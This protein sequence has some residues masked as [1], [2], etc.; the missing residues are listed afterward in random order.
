MFG[1]GSRQRKEVDYSDQ[2]TEKQWLRAIEDGNLDELETPRRKKSRG[3]G[4]GK[5]GSKRKR[6]S[7]PDEGPKDKKKR[8]RPAAEKR[9]PNPTK[10]TAQM[11]KLLAMVCEYK[12]ADDRILIEPFEKLPSRRELPDY[13]EVI[14]KPVDI[15]KMKARIREHRYRSLDDLEEDFMRLCKNAQT[16]NIEDSPIFNDSI[17]LQ[18]VFTSCREKLEREQPDLGED[19]NETDEDEDEEVTDNGHSNVRSSS[20]SELEHL[21]DDDDDDEDEDVPKKSK[22]KSKGSPSTPSTSRSKGRQARSSKKQKY[23]SESEESDDTD[24]D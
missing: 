11:K 7:S 10:L 24:D 17:V 19:D 21:Q 4:E 6:N 13:Y 20:K 12:D 15:V 18:S 3:K 23:V 14:K 5:S 1:R 2:L 8:G 22:S 16:Y 9:S